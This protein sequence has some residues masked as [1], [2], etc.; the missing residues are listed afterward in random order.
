MVWMICIDISY[1]YIEV[2]CLLFLKVHA[3]TMTMTFEPPVFFPAHC[4]LKLKT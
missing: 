4:T 3:I 1:V 2:E